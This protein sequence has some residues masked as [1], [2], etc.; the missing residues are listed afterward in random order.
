KLKCVY[1]IERIKAENVGEHL[2][3]RAFENTRE[4]PILLLGHSDTVHPRGSFRQNPTRIEDDKFYGCGIFDM[5]AN[6]VLML[7]ILRAFDALDLKP[8][9]PITIL[10]SC[11]EE[12]G[13]FTGRELVE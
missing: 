4:K 6:C 12:I 5:K 2:I 3:V 13:S 7:E 9:K 8:S 11:D 10:L 1:S